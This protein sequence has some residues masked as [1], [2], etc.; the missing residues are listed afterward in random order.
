MIFFETSILTVF[1]V[2]IGIG[3]T[4]LTVGYFGDVGRGGAGANAA[5][6]DFG[7]S[8]MIYPAVK[9]SFYYQVIFQVIFVCLISTIFPVLRAL[10]LKP[11]EAIHKS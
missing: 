1:G 9:T 7:Y 3:L 2:P 4:M 10:R 6:E 11:I 5:I 8:T